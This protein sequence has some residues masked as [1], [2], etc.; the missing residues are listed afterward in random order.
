M[1]PALS[2][3]ISPKS[4]GGDGYTHALKTAAGLIINAQSVRRLLAH[5]GAYSDNAIPLVSFQTS[6]KAPICRACV[7]AIE[8]EQRRKHA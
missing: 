3:F 7:Q 5:C 2:G 1:S 6:A 4:R 8:A